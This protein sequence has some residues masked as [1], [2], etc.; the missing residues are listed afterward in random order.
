MIPLKQ[1]TAKAIKFG[2]LLDATD[3]VTAESGLVSALDHATTG[4]TLA[5]N[6]GA[7]AVRHATVTTSAHDSNGYYNLTLDATDTATL[8]PLLVAFTNAACLPHWQWCEVLTAN[9]YDV[10]MGTDALQVDAREIGGV[11][12]TSISEQTSVPAVSGATLV[13]QI[14]W[15]YHRFRNKRTLTSSALIVKRADASTTMATEAIS[16]DG[17]TLT[18]GAAT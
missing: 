12:I 7:F 14:G 6:H 15:L 11:D 9:A 18:E 17:T 10:R 13:Q 16:D 1:S 3:G 2:P 5:K 8:G 4:V